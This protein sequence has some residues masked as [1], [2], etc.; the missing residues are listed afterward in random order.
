MLQVTESVFL[1]TFSF[2]DY[3]F[4]SSVL[5]TFFQAQTMLAGH[6]SEKS[7]ENML[8]QVCLTGLLNRAAEGHF[9]EKF[10][11]CHTKSLQAGIIT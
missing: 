2:T 11:Q 9:K 6:L 4:Y 3:K 10:F 5:Q 8:C 1:S 7:F